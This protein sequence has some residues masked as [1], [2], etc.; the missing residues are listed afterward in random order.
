MRFNEKGVG[1][2][3]AIDGVDLH[4]R[5][6]LPSVPPKA[7]VQLVHGYGEHIGRYEYVAKRLTQSAFAVYGY[8][9]RGHGRS[10]GRR[11]YINDFSELV[12]DLKTVFSNIHQNF[13]TLPCFIL[14]HSLG[15]TVTLQ[16]LIQ[17]P[18]K[19]VGVALSGT[20]VQPVAS[21]PRPIAALSGALGD[22]L[23]RI[24]TITL[25][26][27]ALSK[28][29]NVV[30][31]YKND[32]FVF[33]KAIPARS[34]AAMNRAFTNT[35]KNLGFVVTPLLI[36]HGGSDRLIAPRGSEL[37]YEKVGSTDKTLEVLEGLNHEILNEP[38]K[39]EVIDKI[40]DWFSARIPK[41]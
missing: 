40:T 28:D 33:S 39:D 2:L 35:R 7:I 38:E 12:T 13:P 23:P 16:L 17:D 19:V 37:A 1:T 34:G 26:A 11:G 25:D 15:T 9:M 4:C 18:P 30:R 8:D 6:W 24:P 14:A 32:P 41:V 20:A 3:Q 10:E 5:C 29:E 27:A 22:L 31:N 36:L 21:V